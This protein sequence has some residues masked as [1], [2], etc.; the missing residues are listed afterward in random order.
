[1][2]DATGLL[3]YALRPDLIESESLTQAAQRYGVFSSSLDVSVAGVSTLLAQLC[4]TGVVHS[5]GERGVTGEFPQSSFQTQARVAFLRALSRHH[6]ADGVGPRLH[7]FSLLK[8]NVTDGPV[9]L[10]RH[11]LECA[12]EFWMS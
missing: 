3:L 9:S 6:V 4:A 12:P 11:R 5:S 1:M 2:V 10:F 8:F 7:A